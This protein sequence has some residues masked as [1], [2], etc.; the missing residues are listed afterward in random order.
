MAKIDQKA[1]TFVLLFSLFIKF[2]D[3]SPPDTSVQSGLQ[4]HQFLVK[5]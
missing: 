4:E 1:W 5:I 2:V 3:L